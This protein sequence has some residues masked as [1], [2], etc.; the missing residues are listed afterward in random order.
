M[1]DELQVKNGGSIQLT[2]LMP[3]ATRE[4]LLLA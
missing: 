2:R 3:V 1:K 4:E